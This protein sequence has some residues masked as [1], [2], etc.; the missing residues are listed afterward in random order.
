MVDFVRIGFRV[1]E[2]RAGSV[3]GW[4]RRTYS[5]RSPRTR[6]A[7]ADRAVIPSAS[8]QPKAEGRGKSRTWP[9]VVIRPI[10]VVLPPAS[11]NQSAPSGPVVIPSVPHMAVGKGNSR[12]R[13]LVVMRPIRLN[14]SSVNQ[15]APSGPAVI[16][17]G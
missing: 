8:R 9:L 17:C 2:R 14:S 10:Q 16:D 13:P 3:I 5:Y 12:T 6:A 4:S 1:S 11:M 7:P 15:S